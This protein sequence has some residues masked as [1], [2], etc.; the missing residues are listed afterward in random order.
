MA[1]QDEAFGRITGLSMLFDNVW[2]NYYRSAVRPRQHRLYSGS[3]DFISSLLIWCKMAYL[4]VYYDFTT[5]SCLGCLLTPSY[6][7]PRPKIGSQGSEWHAITI[8]ATNPDFLH[9]ILTPIAFVPIKGLSDP[10]VGPFCC[11][12]TPLGRRASVDS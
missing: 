12:P 3:T 6:S 4:V 9:T 5:L 7:Y 10:F 2:T 1:K 11:R 8:S